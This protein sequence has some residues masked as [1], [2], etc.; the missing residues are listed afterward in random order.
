M[1]WEGHQDSSVQGLDLRAN[2]PVSARMS[3]GPPNP[4][5]KN[6]KP[7]PARPT[8][9]PVYLIGMHLLLLP[10]NLNGLIR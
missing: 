8:W 6:Y 2:R 4:G 9:P 3:V 1:T 7:S 10:V 5:V